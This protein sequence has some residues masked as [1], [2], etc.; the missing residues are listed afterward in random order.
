MR[1][2]ALV[3]ISFALLLST[4]SLPAPGISQAQD[5]PSD[6]PFIYYY[7]PLY[8]AFIIERADGTDARLLGE[9]LQ[10]DNYANASWGDFSPSG[11]W[12]AWTARASE[13]VRNWRL[14]APSAVFAV[15]ADG[16]RSVEERRL[17]EALAILEP[18]AFAEWSPTED[19]L[20]VLHYVGDPAGDTREFRATLVNVEAR[21]GMFNYTKVIGQHEFGYLK[22]SP[23]GDAFFAAGYQ[24]SPLTFTGAA[25]IAGPGTVF[26]WQPPEEGPVGLLDWT[27]DGRLLMGLR[28]E[29]AIILEDV[30]SG[31]RNTLPVPAGH[32]SNV[33]WS[34]DGAG[35]LLRIQI[36]DA[37]QDFGWWPVDD[38]TLDEIQWFEA[39]ADMTS[40]R[41]DGNAPYWSPDGT[42]A[43][44]FNQNDERFYLLDTV[45]L[46]M[47]PLP[48]FPA[49]SVG[50]QNVARW[51]DDENLLLWSGNGM[52]EVNITSGE[53]RTFSDDMVTAG[54]PSP[55]GDH[56]FYRG[57]CGPLRD[58][59]CVRNETT[60][61]VAALMPNSA[62]YWQLFRPY[63][64]TWHPDGEWLFWEENNNLGA[65]FYP[66]YS[67]GRR[68]GTMQR[69]LTGLT[70]F[71][72][73]N[74]I[75]W[76]PERVTEMPPASERPLNPAPVRTMRHDKLVLATAWSPDGSQLASIDIA[77][78]LVL[79]DATNGERRQTLV[80]ASD[81]NAEPVPV[82]ALAWSPDG[83]ELAQI[84]GWPNEPQ[85]TVFDLEGN[86][87]MIEPV[88]VVD[89]LPA[90]AV[91]RVV[92]H[93]DVDALPER[94]GLDADFSQ[95]WQ[96]ERTLL[97]VGFVD[98]QPATL[99][100]NFMLT[101]SHPEGDE[102]RQLAPV[103]GH[104]GSLDMLVQSPDGRWLAYS[105][106]YSEA[107][108][109][110]DYTTGEVA[111][112]VYG[113][114][115]AFSFSPDSRLLAVS[116][117]NEVRVFEM[118]VE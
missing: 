9:G 104:A 78:E 111:M 88:Q 28:D 113:T 50:V 24:R 29:P 68:D 56:F 82:T 107:I 66:F 114:G 94:F 92:S 84:H 15:R 76:L 64:S 86:T 43:A 20:A 12:F 7:S 117:V 13:Q 87:R 30:F 61:E 5:A 32:L 109:I 52:S 48:E 110:Y 105:G 106:F 3:L 103:S 115:R 26:S 38:S 25:I 97:A 23:T 74:L 22:W 33:Y 98:G 112:Q 116:M 14:V 39:P 77:G 63:S 17:G 100:E 93:S 101:I 69:D 81:E 70:R 47:T 55:D 46:T 21:G 60:G 36:P 118:P 45:E 53:S 31:E 79:W 96:L 59:P 71:T 99:D 4:I 35:G 89:S 102:I 65:D 49:D 58:M 57:A 90:E 44:V 75:G 40:F 42:R 108:T 80:E 51:L 91:V 8:H 6:A 67:V 10:P 95:V 16:S 18:V 83:D 27:P 54:N 62:A 72:S 34:P 37:G 11:R 73:G 85:V 2:L 41:H 1:K 19:L